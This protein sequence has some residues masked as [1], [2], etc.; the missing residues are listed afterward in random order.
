[1]SG[2]IKC[3]ECDQ[4]VGNARF[5]TNCGKQ[6]VHYDAANL[7]T[8]QENQKVIFDRNLYPLCLVS[9]VLCSPVHLTITS[10]RID[11]ASGCCCGNLDTLDMR[12]V[13]DI[14]FDRSC[15]EMC[16][17]RGTITIFS[18][19]ETHPELKFSCFGAKRVFTELRT[20]W[21]QCKLSTVVS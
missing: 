21:N 13:K 3:S 12:R 2:A 15:L 8:E 14:G 6:N 19:D 11:T 4:T 1:M 10:K 7:S 9:C 16:I 20:T 17:N 18:A 5:C